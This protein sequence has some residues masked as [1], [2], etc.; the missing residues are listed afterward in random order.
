LLR[1]LNKTY[2]PTSITLPPIGNIQASSEETMSTVGSSSSDELS[3]LGSFTV[4]GFNGAETGC[5]YQQE[6][7]KEWNL[8]GGE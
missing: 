8:E 6:Q 4:F 1:Y 3:S 5:Y 2:N 7:G